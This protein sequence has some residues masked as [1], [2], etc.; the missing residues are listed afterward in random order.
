LAGIVLG[1]IGAAAMGRLL[2]SLLYGVSPLDPLTLVL[3]SALFLAVALLAALIPAE[4]A[5]R[6]PPAVALQG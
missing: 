2:A 4:R 6:T 5:S 1:L 3:G